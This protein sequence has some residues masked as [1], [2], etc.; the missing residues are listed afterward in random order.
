MSE[1]QKIDGETVGVR[2]HRTIDVS[3][4]RDHM[5]AIGH[6]PSPPAR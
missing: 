4:A 6:Q 1:I 2:D 5:L 3:G